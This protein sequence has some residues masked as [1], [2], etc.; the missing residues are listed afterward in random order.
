MRKERD[1]CGVVGEP[2]DGGT[3]GQGRPERQCRRIERGREETETTIKEEREGIRRRFVRSTSS[4]LPSFP[5]THD[6]MQYVPEPPASHDPFPEEFNFSA[7]LLSF[8]KSAIFAQIQAADSTDP[9]LRLHSHNRNP[10]L[11]QRGQE[12]LL[13]SE[14]VLSTEEAGEQVLTEVLVSQRREE[15]IAELAE[16]PL[17]VVAPNGATARTKRG[18]KAKFVNADGV[19]IVQVRL[20]QYREILSIVDVRPFVTML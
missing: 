12:K 15:A 18:R 8:N 20:K 16:V 9:S 2:R 13:S 6:Y 5:S 14:N 1:S 19:R 17:V 4:S 3:N 11:A 10:T 7:G